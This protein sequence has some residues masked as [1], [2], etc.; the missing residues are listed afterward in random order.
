V[1]SIPTI[2]LFRDAALLFNARGTLPGVSLQSLID[3]ARDLNMT[4][5][6]EEA[7]ALDAQERRFEIGRCRTR[8]RLVAIRS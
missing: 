5:V 1:E 2:M 8:A 4:R 7:A 3:K 6:S